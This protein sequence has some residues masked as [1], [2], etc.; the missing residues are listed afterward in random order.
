MYLVIPQGGFV[1]FWRGGV[2]VGII[3]RLIFLPYVTF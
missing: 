2:T 3:V 1:V